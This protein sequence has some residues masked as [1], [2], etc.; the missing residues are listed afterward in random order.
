MLLL[1]PVAGNPQVFCDPPIR[2]LMLRNL[3]YIEIQAANVA[4]LDCLTL[5]RH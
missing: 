4:L 1:P 5:L 2:Y 3:R